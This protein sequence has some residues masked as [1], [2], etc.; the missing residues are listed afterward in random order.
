MAQ[1]DGFCSEPCLF[2]YIMQASKIQ[3]KY[4]NVHGLA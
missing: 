4:M 1:G 3:E 2:W